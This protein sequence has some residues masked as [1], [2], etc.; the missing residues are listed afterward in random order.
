MPAL[1]QRSVLWK[2]SARLTGWGGCALHTNLVIQPHREVES[3]DVA[4]G[5]AGQ[6]SQ[7]NGGEVESGLN[8]HLLRSLDASFVL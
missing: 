4:I 2:S 7:R 6:Q 3:V 1:G 5:V 8:S